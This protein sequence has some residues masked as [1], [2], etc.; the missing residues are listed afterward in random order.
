MTGETA[1]SSMAERRLT[2]ESGRGG[3]SPGYQLINGHISE[4]FSDPGRE[5]AR[6]QTCGL[7]SRDKNSLDINLSEGRWI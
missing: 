7:A 2:L 1:Q 4:V 3:S 6:A 5:F